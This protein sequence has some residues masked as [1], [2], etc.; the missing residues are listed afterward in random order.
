M[1]A[2]KPRSLPPAQDTNRQTC[3]I[4]AILSSIFCILL[5]SLGYLARP[6]VLELYP[7]VVEQIVP[8]TATAVPTRPVMTA[9]P[10]IGT[11]PG[12][13]PHRIGIR[14]VDGV[15]EFYD[16]VTGKKFIPRGYNYV[17]LSP[18]FGTSGQMWEETLAPGYYDPD[19]LE[20][21]LRQMHTDGYNVLRVIV[22]CCRP[23]KNVGDPRGGLSY[24][25]VENIIDVLK[26]AK[27][28]EIQVILVLHLA[29]ADGGYS[30]YWEP[31]IP[32][33]D[34]L[35]LFFLT[36]GGHTTKRLYDQDLIRALIKRNAPLDTV[37]AYDLIGDA[38][39]DLSWPP[40]S[41]TTGLVTTAN[42]KKYDMSQPDE[43]QKMMNENYVYWIDRQRAA[44]LQVDPTAL[45]TVSFNAFLDK[46][47]VSYANAAIWQSNAD[48][49]D[50]HLFFGLRYTLENYVLKFGT[51]GL[52]DKPIIIGQLAAA[53]QGYPT[54]AKAAQALVDVQ[55]DSCFYGFDGWILWLYGSEADT[56]LWNGPT[57]GGA[58]ND[59][60]APANRPD[61]CRSD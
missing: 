21:A 32:E 16:R 54:A 42:G 58:I 10:Q 13:V 7:Y 1:D 24:P 49:F 33:F 23:G 41:S 27:A 46:S 31:Y 38:G 34:K 40:L 15:A 14:L 44:I 48:F 29:A 56:A 19:L 2:R 17:R 51:L 3:I 61:P 57:D 20:L 11:L 43:K 4:L 8:P 60:L 47:G 28:H 36:S 5:L 45:V 55:V 18:I 59:A 25:Y 9:V 6:A 37:L 22:D 53:K 30:Q 50:L 12:Y 39:Y 52:N 26:R 35:N